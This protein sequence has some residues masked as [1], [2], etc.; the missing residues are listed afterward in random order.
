MSPFE[1]SHYVPQILHEGV[2]QFAE[3]CFYF[4]KTFGPTSRALALVSVYL[5]PD[6]HLLQH[7]HSTLLVCR[8]QSE[9]LQVIDAKAILSVVA[10]VPFPFSVGNHTNQHFV[11]EKIGL[12]VIEVGGPVDDSDEDGP[13]DDSDE[14]GSVDDDEDN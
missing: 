2:I 5:T 7:S 12:D 1:R 6:E 11:I 8:Y 3:V 13:I 10:M 4:I 14:D 9:A